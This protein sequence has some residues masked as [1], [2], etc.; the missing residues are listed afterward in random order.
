MISSTGLMLEHETLQFWQ[1]QII[2]GNK[3]SEYTI[4]GTN[5]LKEYASEAQLFLL[6]SFAIF[7]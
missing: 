5:D 4:N 2:E 7:N 3:Q 1:W 6:N